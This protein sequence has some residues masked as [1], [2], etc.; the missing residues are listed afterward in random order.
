[1]SITDPTN[2]DYYQFPNGAEA[3]DIT[4]HLS[5][6]GAQAVQYIVRAT[7]TDGKIKGDPLEDLNK[8][9]WFIRRE[10]QRIGGAA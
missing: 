1:M 10:I 8:A 4:Q 7:R 2:P 3:I 9:I 5:G 6:C